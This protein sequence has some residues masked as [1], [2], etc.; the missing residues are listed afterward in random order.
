LEC[1]REAAAFGSSSYGEPSKTSTEKAV[2]A[3]PQS[4]GEAAAFGSSSCGEFPRTSAEKAVAA[5]PQ[6]KSGSFAAA[7]QR[8]RVYISPS[9]WFD[10]VPANVWEF[11][12][13]GYQVCEKWLKDRRGRTLSDEDIL[14]YQRVVV[15]LNETIRLM[16]EIDQVIEAHGGWPGAF[17]TK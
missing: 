6:S 9:R 5:R 15:A 10:G 7:L 12:I 16:A 1:G 11:H 4:E 13:G 17:V 8:G 14:H 3:R 2:A